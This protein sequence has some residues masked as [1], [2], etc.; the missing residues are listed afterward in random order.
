[1]FDLDTFADNAV[2]LREFADDY[3]ALGLDAGTAARWANR[4]LMP[5]E[6][7]RWI[8]ERHTPERASYWANKYTISPAQ[9]RKE[10]ENR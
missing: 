4:G 6:A 1:M 2:Q 8:A 7:A 9:A 10:D 5:E 3:A